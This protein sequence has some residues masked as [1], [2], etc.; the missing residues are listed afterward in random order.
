MCK[1]VS[2]YHGTHL[3]DKLLKQADKNIEEEAKKKFG[4]GENISESIILLKIG[5]G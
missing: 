4:C 3:S 5:F 2:L 1:K